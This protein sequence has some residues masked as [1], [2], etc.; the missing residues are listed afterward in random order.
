MSSDYIPPTFNRGDSTDLSANTEWISWLISQLILLPSSRPTPQ[1]DWLSHAP[2]DYKVALWKCKGARKDVEREKKLLQMYY[3]ELIKYTGDNPETIR[4]SDL[5]G[6]KRND[7]VSIPWT[8]MDELENCRGDKS[9]TDRIGEINEETSKAK[10]DLENVGANTERL[11]AQI[12]GYVSK[13]NDGTEASWEKRLRKRFIEEIVRTDSSSGQSHQDILRSILH[14]FASEFKDNMT[15]ASQ[16][17]HTEV[18]PNGLS[19]TKSSGYPSSEYSPNGV[20]FAHQTTTPMVS[21]C[22]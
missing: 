17:E 6:Q 18:I 20:S 11:R 10:N 21:A 19:S 3:K 15:K 8:D 5:E 22:A 1:D 16:K 13:R 9:W 12:N 7:R 14:K 2:E 4:M